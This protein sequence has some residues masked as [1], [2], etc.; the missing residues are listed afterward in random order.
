[1][2]FEKNI[3]MFMPYLDQFRGAWGLPSQNKYERW[4]KTDCCNGLFG[5]FLEVHS[6]LERPFLAAAGAATCLL[7]KPQT[8]T[9]IVSFLQ[10]RPVYVFFSTEK[11]IK[12]K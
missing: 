6:A 12:K 8:A 3:V 5:C 2:F 10:I 1:M 7:T 4:H 9:G 11:K